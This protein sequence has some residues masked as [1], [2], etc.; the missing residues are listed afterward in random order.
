MVQHEH[1]TSVR[2][3]NKHPKKKPHGP[4]IGCTCVR[5]ACVTVMVINIVTA[6]VL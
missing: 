1:D 4:L 6:V 3:Q 5:D 2:T